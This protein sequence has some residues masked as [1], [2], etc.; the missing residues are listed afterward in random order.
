MVDLPLWKIWKSV[1]MII[2]NIWTNMFQTT[3]QINMW[4]TFFS[5][6]NQFCTVRCED[7]RIILSR[8]KTEGAQAAVSV[9]FWTQSFPYQLEEI[10]ELRLRSYLY[11]Y[12]Y[13]V[14]IYILYH[15]HI[16]SWWLRSLKGRCF[17]SHRSRYC[18]WLSNQWKWLNTTR[19]K[20]KYSTSC[21]SFLRENSP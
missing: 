7:A 3:N 16:F 9:S 21:P 18:E 15:L 11:L 17:A 4:G 19:T 10:C 2:P 12:V 1:G 13:N 8:N 6:Q 5:L 20:K 14:Y